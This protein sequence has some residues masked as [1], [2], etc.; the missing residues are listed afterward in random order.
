MTFRGRT[1]ALLIGIAIIASS[2][3]T[4]AWLNISGSD[5]T[6]QKWVDSEPLAKEGQGGSKGD[7]SKEDIPEDL[8]KVFETYRAIKENYFTKVEDEELINGAIE[9]MVN[10]LKDPYSTYM[11]QKASKHFSESLESTFQGIGA[12]VTIKDGKVTI[13]A[14]FKDSPADKAGLKANDQILSVNGESI[15]GLSLYEAVLKIRGPKGS[16]ANLLIKRSGSAEPIE[17]KVVRDEIPI[18]TVFSSTVERNGKIFGKIEISQFAFETDQH[19]IEKLKSLEEKGIDGLIIDVRGNPGGLL[20]TVLTISEELVPNKGVI[21]HV[22][23]RN[24]EKKTFNSKLDGKK[25][26]PIVVLV[27]EESASASEILASALKESGDYPII[28]Q[29]TF[30]KGTVQSTVEMSDKSSLKLTIAKWLT[31]KGNWIH[32]KGVEPTYEVSQPPYFSALQLPKDKVLKRD[33]NGPEISNLQIILQGLGFNVNR[34]DGYFDENTEK[35]MRDF[36]LNNNLPPTGL[37][38]KDT[39]D[40]LEEKLRIKLSDPKNDNQLQKAIEVLVNLTEKK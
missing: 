37:L 3:L 10:S 34:S 23:D 21:L 16:V 35:A 18:E 2:L 36:Q 28:G 1:V 6:M 40:L 24:G 15:E 22:T 29:K 9:G 13:V 4:L 5:Y 38:D 32:E 26:Y 19:F 12:E 27:N 20:N 33:M 39:A 8:K 14:P 17:V 7:K 11:D 25:P 31:P 30:G